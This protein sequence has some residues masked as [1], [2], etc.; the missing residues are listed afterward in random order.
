MKEL[1]SI[2]SALF[3][4]AT[5]SDFVAKAHKTGADAIILDLE[6]SIAVDQKISARECIQGAS[7]E[8]ANQGLVVMVRINSEWRLAVR[9]LETSIGKNVQCIIVPK[10]SS[11]EHI[12]IIDEIVTELEMEKGLTI[13]STKL[14]AFIESPSALD[15]AHSIAAA[16]A[17]LVGL[18]LGTEDFSTVVGAKPNRATL[19]APCQQIIFAAYSAGIRAFG[20]PDSIANFADV[21]GFRET[22]KLSRD[23]GFRGACCI[24]PTQVKIINQEFSP[25]AEEIQDAVAIVSNFENAQKNGSAAIAYKGQMIDAPVYA[26]AKRLL[27]TINS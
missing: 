4:P 2:K 27:E 9:D 24:H 23:M 7:A 1:D 12:K 16:S 6:D 13:G 8:I 14:L 5:K 10:A 18:S 15:K 17:R 11:E 3:M 25:S 20:F 22:I 26:R 21:E 19:Y